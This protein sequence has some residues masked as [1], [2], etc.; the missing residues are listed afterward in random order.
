MTWLIAV[1]RAYASRKD[2]PHLVLT[3]LVVI[4]LAVMVKGLSRM[5]EHYRAQGR[6]ECQQA[7]TRT[8]LQVVTE[9][10]SAVATKASE[11]IARSQATGNTFES[12]RGRIAAHFQRLET[13][14]RHAPPSPSDQ[15]ELPAARLRLWQS[16]NDGSSGPAADADQGA[17]AAQPAAVAASA[18][19]ASLWP[20]AGSG[21]Q[22]PRG[23]PGLSPTGG[24][25]LRAAALP[26]VITQ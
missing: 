24:A 13:E 12:A 26:G 16:A 3:F 9:G 8:T 19:P 6:A 14:A 18:A 15:C 25:A 1:W 23:G 17:S 2:L 21:S 5:P 10:A 4:A 7:V 20:H 22:P 11:D